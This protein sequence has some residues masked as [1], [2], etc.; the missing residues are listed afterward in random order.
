MTKTIRMHEVQA[1][2]EKLF[3]PKLVKLSSKVDEVAKRVARLERNRGATP[4]QPAEVIEEGTI[5]I[6]N[7]RD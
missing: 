2:A 7:K 3:G 1:A 4:I 5:L 6:D